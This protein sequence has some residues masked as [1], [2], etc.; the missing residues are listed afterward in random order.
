MS[1]LFPPR[2]SEALTLQEGAVQAARDPIEVSV[3]DALDL[4]TQLAEASQAGDITAEARA[5]RERVLEG[6]FFVACLGQ[7]KRG[8]STL[9]NALLGEALLPTGV[10]PVTS[11]VTV[12]RHGPLRARVRLG[13]GDWREA[14]VEK[15]ADYVSETANQENRLGVT[16]VEVFC[17]S[18]FLEH[19][20]CLVDTPGVGSIFAGNTEDAHAFVPHVDAA[21]VVLGGDPPISQD[22]LRLI[23]ELTPRVR[24]VFV[25]L[26]KADKLSP[27]EL[28]EARA[29]TEQ[30]LRERAAGAHARVFEVSGLERLRGEGPPRQWGELVSAI[31]ELA[32]AKGPELVDRAAARGL[33]GLLDRLLK[34]LREERSALVRPVEETQRRLELLRRCER[35]AEQSLVELTHLFNAEEQQLER[36]DDEA[37]ARFVHRAHPEVVRALQDALVRAPVRRGP[38]LR[39]WLV[40]EAQD[41]VERMVRGWRAERQPQVEHDFAQVTERFVTHAN[42][43]L[44]RLRASGQVTQDALP[45][46]VMPAVGLKARSR[47]SFTSLMRVRTQS[48]PGWVAEVFRPEGEAAPAALRVASA[49]ATH[50]LQVNA[51]RL[52]TDLLERVIEGRRDIESAVRRTLQDVVKV[53][54][55]AAQRAQLARLGGEQAI[56]AEVTRIDGLLAA[57]ETLTSNS[58]TQN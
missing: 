34:R 40:N 29:F 12:V 14:P 57:V 2:S 38:A 20:L 10:P 51:K 13:A 7:F 11:V 16:G 52:G 31:T 28:A 55:H 50:L 15:L 48:F 17:P 41:V 23:S 44:A 8:K 9:I 19:G 25:A 36:R 21:I 45:V 54:E 37:F 18:P 6:R 33:R 49:F 32:R 22:E 43:F 53:A 5:L 27:P 56:A 24:D 3:A 39:R 35:E 46:D 1:G 4:L 47:F 42:A 26:N 58:L 30:V